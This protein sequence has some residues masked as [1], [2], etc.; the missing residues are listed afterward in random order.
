MLS[1]K[2]TLDILSGRRRGLAAACLR[3]LLAVAEPLYGWYVRRRNRGYDTG[4]LPI[5]RVDA[6]V[7]SVGN[8]TVGGTGKT[9]LVCWLAQ[10]FASRGIRVTLISRGYGRAGHKSNDEALELAARLPGVPHLQNADR[11]AAARQAL[12][13]ERQILILDDAFQHRRIARDL[14]IVLVDAL[15]PFGYGRLL[16]RGLL[17][18]PLEGLSRAQVV[19]LS[20]ADA[21]SAARREEIRREVARL[22]PQATW[23]ELAHQPAALVNRAGQSAKLETLRGKPVLAFCGI[24]NPA[25][26]AHTLQSAGMSVLSL[27]EFPDHH[28]YSER[29]LTALDQWAASEPRAAAVVCTHKDLVKI[30]RDKLGPLP[31]WAVTVE[32]VVSSGL[33]KLQRHLDALSARLAAGDV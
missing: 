21:V 8:L 23:I 24:G 6:P 2:A 12:A 3:S 22:A 33:A 30:P 4:R 32:I 13:P 25:G 14:D 1:G 29:D 20:R 10:W 26:Y 19:G 5:T 9:P 16:P 15:E 31:L 27:R 17:R 18:E 28:G 11:V 7:I